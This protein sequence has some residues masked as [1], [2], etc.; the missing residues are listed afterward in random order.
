MLEKRKLEE[1]NDGHDDDPQVSLEGQLD[2]VIVI[3]FSSFSF[4]RL[5]FY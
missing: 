4:S 1:E 5:H 3:I 2:A